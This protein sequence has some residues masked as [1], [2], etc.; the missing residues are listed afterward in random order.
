[1]ANWKVEALYVT[2]DNDVVTAVAWACSGNNTMRSKLT[3]G[4]PGEPFIDYADL[5]E[6]KVLGWVW[7]KVD[8]TFIEND[9]DAASAKMAAI[10]VKPL[11]WME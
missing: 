2:P 5:T 6:D 8:K 10:T 4:P 1:M 11:P 7:A 9:V 3:L